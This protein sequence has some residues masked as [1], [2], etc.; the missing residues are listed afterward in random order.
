M[1]ELEVNEALREARKAKHFKIENQKY[2]DSLKKPVQKIEFDAQSFEKALLRYNE[3]HN[4]GFEKNNYNSELFVELCKY[5]TDTPCKFN[6]DKGLF[7]F[8]R[9]GTGKST[10]MKLFSINQKCSYRIVNCKVVSDELLNAG[11]NFDEVLKSYSKPYCG[12]IKNDFGNSGQMGTCFDDLGTEDIINSFG[13]KR[14]VM[15][16]ILLRCYDSYLMKGIIHITTNNTKEMILENYG[17]RFVS[18]RRIG[19]F[20]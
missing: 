16:D 20:R 13:N 8:G 1:T 14:S 3:S 6:P 18:R 4:I 10:L 12:T 5:F 17:D 11:N 19:G 7:I 9:T 15:T 2:L